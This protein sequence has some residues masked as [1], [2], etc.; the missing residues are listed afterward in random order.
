MYEIVEIFVDSSLRQY[1]S[2]ALRIVCKVSSCLVVEQILDETIAKNTY[3]NF[4]LNEYFMNWTI[5]RYIELLF[6]N[7]KGKAVE[8][9]K[10]SFTIT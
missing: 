4:S 7:F 5:K 8:N 9:Q 1:N 2:V 10:L 6:R 3:E